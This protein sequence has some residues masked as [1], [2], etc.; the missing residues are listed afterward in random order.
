ML[1]KKVLTRCEELTNYPSRLTNGGGVESTGCGVNIARQEGV[2]VGA[3][4]NKHHRSVNI[5]S[6][7]IQRINA[8]IHPIFFE[9]IISRECIQH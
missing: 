2:F 1:Y 6:I 5:S 7:K 3:L 9:K 8:Y 4:K